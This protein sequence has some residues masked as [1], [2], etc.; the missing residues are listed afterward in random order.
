M[1]KASSNQSF[2]YSS[3]MLYVD[4]AY[5]LLWV[6]SLCICNLHS[7]C[8]IS[9]IQPAF[10]CTCRKTPFAAN[11]FIETHLTLQHN[12]LSKSIDVSAIQCTR[13]LIKSGFLF[14]NLCQCTYSISTKAHVFRCGHVCIK[15]SLH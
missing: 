13:N 10:M 4:H 3:I 5:H 6:K 14:S 1:P 2:Y 7:L 9:I 12:L 15:V 8:V 11:H